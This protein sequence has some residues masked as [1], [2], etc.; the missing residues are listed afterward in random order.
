MK[1]T[2]SVIIVFAKAPV[3]GQVNTRLIPAIGE[4]Q[5]TRLQYEL[6]HQRLS[7]LTQPKLC[8]V[9]LYC[10]PDIS[11]PCFKECADEYSVNLVEQQGV[12]LGVRMANAIEEQ[13]QYFKNVVVVGTDAPA[14]ELDRIE[15][16]IVQLRDGKEVVVVPAS[17]GGYV[18]IGMSQYY[19]ALF[20]SVPWGTDRVMTKTRGNSVAAGLK[21][22]ELETCWDI[23]TPEDYARYKQT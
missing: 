15:Q 12:D 9:L 4:E 17:D 19:K 1:Y 5:A 23:D 21:M 20:C 13:S 18:L 22:V 6:I 2:D 16:A 3:P 10:A 8:E 11:H 14:L 7:L